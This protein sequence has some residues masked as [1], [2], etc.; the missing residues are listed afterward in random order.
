[1]TDSPE[2][3]A[4][5]PQPPKLGRGLIAGFVLAVV[6]VGLFALLWQALGDLGFAQFPRLILAMCVP[7]ALIAVLVGAYILIFRARE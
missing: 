1:M 2:T 5:R 3:Q 6:G 7:P 4:S